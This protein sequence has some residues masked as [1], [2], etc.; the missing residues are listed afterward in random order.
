LLTEDGS[1]Q[2]YSDVGNRSSG[3]W[4][5]VELRS[6]VGYQEL[7]Y[8]IYSQDTDDFEHDFGNLYVFFGA[9]SAYDR[10]H[11][12][13]VDNIRVGKYVNPEPSHGSW[14]AEEQENVWDNY[15]FIIWGTQHYVNMTIDP[16]WYFEINGTKYYI[17]TTATTELW[18][19]GNVSA[20]IH[21]LV[22][23]TGRYYNCSNFWGDD[24]QL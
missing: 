7:L 23:G 8:F 9:L 21:D 22:D 1:N 2:F 19:S 16:A 14:G 3:V 5:E 18:L 24:T 17:N 20:Y 12:F 10:Q 4:H 11:E 6:D 15:A 13:Y